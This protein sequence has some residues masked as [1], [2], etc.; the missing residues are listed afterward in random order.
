MASKTIY[1]YDVANRMFRRTVDPITS[2]HPT[3]LNIVTTTEFNASA[4]TLPPSTRWAN[5][6]NSPITAAATWCAR[7][8]TPVAATASRSWL[9]RRAPATVRR[10]RRRRQT[11]IQFD[12][13]DRRVRARCLTP[14]VRAH[15]TAWD[16]D[17]NGNVIGVVDAAP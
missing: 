15:T 4:T 2:S 6:P 14:T 8:L 17:A 10:R 13:A 16:Y 9:R 12:A 5:A 11:Q 7:W 3:G 1:E